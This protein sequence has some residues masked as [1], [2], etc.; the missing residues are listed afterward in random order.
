[1]RHTFIIFT[2]ACFLFSGAIAGQ[3]HS[4][5]LTAEKKNAIKELLTI[6]GATK[7]GAMYANAFTQQMTAILK[8]TKPDID[9]RAFDLV[10]E[11]VEALIHEEF[12]VKESLL[13][14]LYGIYHKHLTL[15]ETR[16]LIRFYK[17]PLGKKTISVL[18]KMTQESMQA[19]QIWGKS[20]AP[21]I[22]QRVMDRFKKEGINL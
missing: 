18:P 11:E 2:L 1:M 12:V 16:G 22:Q 15:E 6:T 13:P 10:Q 3:A 5:E 9:P 8:K 19:G 14:L 17:T 4:E 7:M 21:K 20:L